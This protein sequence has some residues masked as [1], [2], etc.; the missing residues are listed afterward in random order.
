MRK[1]KPVVTTATDNNGLAP[2]VAVPKL[3]PA[4]LPGDLGVPVIAKYLG[5]E[6]KRS[7]QFN[8]DQRLYQFQLPQDFGAAKFS[9]WSQT[10][11]DLKLG[12]VTRNSIVL[13]QYLGRG[14]GD[15]AQHNWSIRPFRG[16]SA[17]L[18]TLIAENSEGC[19]IVK[20]AIAM[21]EDSTMGQ[22]NDGENDDLPF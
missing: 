20:Q 13:V 6:V 9:L 10:Q 12:S 7:R 14:E 8:R 5:Y 16:T 2:D 11:L 18:Q 1:P 15:R 4:I 19:E 3:I 21:L 22:L 17:Q